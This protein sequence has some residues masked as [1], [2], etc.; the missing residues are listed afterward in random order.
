MGLRLTVNSSTG[1]KNLNPDRTAEN[2]QKVPLCRAETQ[3]RG[4][5]EPGSRLGTG[6]RGAGYCSGPLRGEG[7]LF[8]HTLPP[9]WVAAKL[10][11]VSGR[12]FTAAGT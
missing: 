4:S 8:Q 10:S 2:S 7:R 6:R 9:C 3:V 12:S 11:R 1:K 5:R